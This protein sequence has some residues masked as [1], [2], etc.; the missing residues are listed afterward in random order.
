MH[1]PLVNYLLIFKAMKLDAYRK[2]SITLQWSFQSN[3]YIPYL[4]EITIL[5]NK[6]NK[7]LCWKSVFKHQGLTESSH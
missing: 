6:N 7:W 1:H 5:H 2:Y 3:N 4:L